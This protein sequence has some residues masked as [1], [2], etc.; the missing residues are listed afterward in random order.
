MLCLYRDYF[1]HLVKLAS[2]RPHE[3][4]LG[5]PKCSFLE[6]KWVPLYISGKSTLVKYDSIWPEVCHQTLGWPEFLEAE[7]KRRCGT[8]YGHEWT[9]YKT[10]HQV[11][12]KAVLGKSTLE[13]QGWVRI[14]LPPTTHH[15]CGSPCILVQR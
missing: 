13:L 9:L 7:A 14:V 11:L 10:N 1:N 8:C 2:K 5:P 3:P 15:S 6:G 4:S 12:Y